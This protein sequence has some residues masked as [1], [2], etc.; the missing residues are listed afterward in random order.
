MKR[1]VLD[2]TTERTAYYVQ[3]EEQDNKT[4]EF[5]GSIGGPI[6]KDQFFFY[7][8]YSPRNQKRTN[9]YNFAGNTNGDIPRDTWNQQA[10]GKLTLREPPRQRQLVDAVDA[11]HGHRHAER[12]QR[13][14]AELADLAAVGTG[15]EHHRG[16]EQNQ[17]NTSGT[18][19][20]TL[21]N[22]SFLSARGGLLPRPLHRHG[23]LADDVVHLSEPDD[24]GERDPARRTCRAAPAS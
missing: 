14:D 13:R 20:I 24:G 16:Y 1:L 22:T 21:S 18:V 19:D 9:N 23:H 2:P 15:A 12:L 3:D 17:V 4:N 7:G 11:D 5:G 6:V 8:A 10:F